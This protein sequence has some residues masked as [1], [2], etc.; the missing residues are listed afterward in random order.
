[1][2][3]R[4][5]LLEKFYRLPPCI[6]I[7]HFM[8]KGD[9]P[10]PVLP[11]QTDFASI[12]QRG[13]IQQTYVD[14]LDLGACILYLMDERIQLLEILYHFAE[15]FI[16]PIPCGLFDGRPGF[17]L[18]RQYLPADRLNILHPWADKFQGLVSLLEREVFGHGW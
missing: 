18:V 12:P 14:I 8:P 13:K 1:M 3:N 2:T 15:G 17:R 10:F 7:V 9:L 16:S 6:S 4:E 5:Y 11:A